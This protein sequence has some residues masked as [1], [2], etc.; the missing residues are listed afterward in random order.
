MRYELG[1]KAPI[2]ADKT[3]VPGA[4]RLYPETKI[5]FG[6]ILNTTR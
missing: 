3:I 5:I 1:S 4:I 2:S 6:R